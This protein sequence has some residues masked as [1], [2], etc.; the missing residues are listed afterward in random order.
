MNALGIDISRYASANKLM[1][2]EVAAKTDVRFIAVRE[3]IS[4]AYKDPF[5]DYHWSQIPKMTEWRNTSGMSTDT[6]YTSPNLDTSYVNIDGYTYYG[7]R[8]S[9]SNIEPSGD[10]YITLHSASSATAIYKPIL[11]LQ[12]IELTDLM[13]WF[14]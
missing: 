5:F 14:T 11:V 1:D 7:L 9:R 4:W 2:F 13:F 12:Y 6:V 8:S 3:G 10:E